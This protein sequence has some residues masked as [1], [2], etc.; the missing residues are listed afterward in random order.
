[1]LVLSATATIACS[2][3]A[4]DF[5]GQW[6]Q[7]DDHCQPKCSGDVTLHIEH[8]DPELTVETTMPR[9]LLKPRHAVQKYTTDGSVSASTGADGDEFYTSVVWNGSSLFLSI[10]EHEDGRILRSK[11][12][13]SLIENGATLRRDR[14]RPNDVKRILFFSRQP[15]AARAGEP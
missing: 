11:E 8:H 7:N 1:M 12:T 10:E 2:Q 9:S 5:S 15:N 14:E 6:K 3:T 4:P 13:W